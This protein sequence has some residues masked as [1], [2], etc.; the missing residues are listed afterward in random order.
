MFILLI[1]K[2]NTRTFNGSTNKIDS[3]KESKKEVTHSSDFS[4]PHS[5]LYSSRKNA[6]A[7][8]ARTRVIQAR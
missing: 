3:R 8:A 7:A 5:M 4:F 6:H 1:L 2:S